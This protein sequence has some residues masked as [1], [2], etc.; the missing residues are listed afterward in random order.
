MGKT[1]ILILNIK[2]L[3]K[4]NKRDFGYKSIKKPLN[5][6][7]GKTIIVKKVLSSCEY[8]QGIGILARERSEARAVLTPLQSGVLSSGLTTVTPLAL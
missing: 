4:N 8:S 7:L 3:I 2:I 6:E 5:D 1:P